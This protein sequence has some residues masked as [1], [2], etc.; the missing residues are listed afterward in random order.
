[1]I[2]VKQVVGFA[3]VSIR[4]RNL[5]KIELHALTVVFQSF[6]AYSGA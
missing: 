6:Y 5:F 4:L 1:M 2:I 3:E